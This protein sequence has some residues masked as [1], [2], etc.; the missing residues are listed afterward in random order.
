MGR[1][2]TREV[3]E[4]YLHCKTKAHLKLAGQQGIV[5]DYETLLV[6]NRQEVRQQA[7]AKILAKH[8]EAEVARDI[9]LTVAALQS[10]PPFV[11]DATLEDDSLSLGFDGLKRVDGESKLGDF[12]YVP[13]LFH[14]GGEAGREQRLLL[15]LLG[16]LLS[17]PG[18]GAR[19]RGV[20][21]T[22]G[23]ARPRKVKLGPEGERPAEPAGDQG[24]AGASTPPRLMLNDHC[25]V[26][27]FRQRCHARRRQGRPQPAAGH[28]REGDQQVRP[29]GHLHGHATVLHVPPQEEGQASDQ[30]KQPHQHA[31]QAL[32]IREKKIHILGTPE[33]AR[34]PDANLLRHRGRPGT[35]LRLPARDDCRGGRGRGA[36]LVLGRR[37]GRG[38]SSLPAVPGRRRALRGRR[39]YAYGSYEASVPAAARQEL[40]C[41]EVGRDDPA[42]LGQ[43]SVGHL[44]RTSTSRPTRNGLKDIGRYLGFRWTEADAS[45][46]QSIVWRR[47][48]EET[49]SA[50]FKDKL[51]TYNLEDC[52]A[53]KRV[54]EFLY[55]DCAP[56][57]RASEDERGGA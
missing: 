35:P 53:L 46:I 34:M 11:L 8:P 9:P 10:G 40:K 38:A 44:L 25:Q 21:S 20:C 41:Q 47:R 22:G 19:I 15:E 54:T 24:A 12:H 16:L 1:K 3:L 5:S 13:V 6:A 55:A 27:E 43:R 45:G 17:R 32:A 33:T 31:L 42:A 37:P 51:T 36:A 4:S 18:E 30:R 48:W 56:K 52:A 2:I 57:S 29:Q 39:L 26:C 28:G 23:T 50:A 14:E 7:I 49:H